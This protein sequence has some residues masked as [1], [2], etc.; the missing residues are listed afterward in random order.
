MRLEFTLHPMK[1]FHLNVTVGGVDSRFSLNERC[2][3][4]KLQDNM[5]WMGLQAAYFSKKSRAVFKSTFWN[6]TLV[7][8]HKA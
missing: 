4:Q 6:K 7:L 1:V 8:S 5:A 3:V 2:S